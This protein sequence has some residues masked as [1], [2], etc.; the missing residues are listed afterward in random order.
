MHFHLF[1][2]RPFF[3]RENN[4]K[5]MTGR[6][7]RNKHDYCGVHTAGSSSSSPS[8]FHTIHSSSNTN[9]GSSSLMDAKIV[10][11]L[12]RSSAVMQAN[13]ELLLRVQVPAHLYWV[14]V[15]LKSKTTLLIPRFYGTTDTWL[16]LRFLQIEVHSNSALLIIKLEIIQIQIF[17]HFYVL[18][19]YHHLTI[20]GL[21]RNRIISLVPEFPNYPKMTS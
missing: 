16:R 7:L 17:L 13:S 21:L 15:D 8:S 9:R 4:N 3:S 19:E 12:R 10:E 14:P 11:A 5:T 20:S 1:I 2:F 18:R 6:I